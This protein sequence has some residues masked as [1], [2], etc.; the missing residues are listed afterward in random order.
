M[1]ALARSYVWWPGLDQ[2]IEERAKSCSACQVNK[3]AAPKAPLHPWAWPTVPWQRIHIDFAGPVEGKMLLIIVDAHSKWPEVFIMSTT[4]ST[5]TITK[6]RETFARFGLPEQLVSDNGPQFV[7]EEFETFLKM[8]GVKHLRSAPYH[9]ASNGAAERVVQTVKQAIR[10]GSQNG[11]TLEHALAQF[12]LQYRSTPHATTGMSPS[13]LLLGR[14]LRTRL[15]LLKPNAGRFVRQ[16][17]NCQ[18]TRHDLHSRRQVFFIGEKV[19]VLN[20]RRGPRWH[21]LQSPGASILPCPVGG[22]K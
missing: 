11:L 3:N 14:T 19:W 1:K 2:Q 6:L 12:L 22:W 20:M 18:K 15:D 9:P 8:N 13:A 17:Q 7:P 4:T 5:K 16:Q 21:C 10:A